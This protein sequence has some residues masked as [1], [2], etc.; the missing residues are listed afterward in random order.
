MWAM[1]E[2]L[3]G[4]LLRFV[5]SR[6]GCQADVALIEPNGDEH[7]VRCLLKSDGT[8]LGG[9]GEVLA[10]LTRRYGAQAVCLTAQGVVLGIE[11]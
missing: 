11:G 7:D 2:E 8:D 4:R 6:D 10:Y 1:A 3:R 5:P 9:D